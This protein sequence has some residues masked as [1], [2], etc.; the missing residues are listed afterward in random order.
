MISVQ[1]HYSEPFIGHDSLLITENA[2]C[3]RCGSTS[4]VE[5]LR[6]RTHPLTE[7][8]SAPPCLGPSRD[9]TS[10]NSTRSSLHATDYPCS[11]FA[12]S[13]S[14]LCP[15]LCP[16]RHSDHFNSPLNLPP[17]FK[18]HR[19]ALRS[20]HTYRHCNACMS[21]LLRDRMREGGSLRDIR[22]FSTYT[23]TPISKPASPPSPHL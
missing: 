19:R 12:H 6:C 11:N 3:F 20:P 15:L 5:M 23:F 17:P 7:T 10:T 9:L 1:C 2:V 14:L 18:V 16:H 4:V 22:S 13:S 21:L 8:T